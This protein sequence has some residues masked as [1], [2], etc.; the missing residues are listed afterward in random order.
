VP[1]GMMQ[2][3]VRGLMHQCGEHFR[4]RLSWQQR[5]TA[6][7]GDPQSRSNVF[8]IL[9]ANAA[10]EDKLAQAV[11]IGTDFARGLTERGLRCASV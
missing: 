9:E 4:L 2:E 10:G 1:F 8:A 11:E 5:N 7:V 6:S 3:L